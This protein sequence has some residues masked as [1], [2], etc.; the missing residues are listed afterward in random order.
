[1][2]RKLCS[3]WAGC[4]SGAADTFLCH[5]AHSSLNSWHTAASQVVINQR[6]L[7]WVICSACSTVHWLWRTDTHTFVPYILQLSLQQSFMLWT[8]SVQQFQ[9][10]WTTSYT[11]AWA[12]YPCQFFSLLPDLLLQSMDLGLQLTDCHTVLSNQLIITALQV[13]KSRFHILWTA[14]PTRWWGNSISLQWGITRSFTPRFKLP[15]FS[16]NCQLHHVLNFIAASLL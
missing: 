6:R 4:I 2:S 15:S 12:A 5:T 9:H 13:G 8:Q 16:H 14:C 11:I 10:R 1:M 7:W 3:E